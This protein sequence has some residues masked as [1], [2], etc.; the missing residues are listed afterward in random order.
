MVKTI[1]CPI[2]PIGYLVPVVQWDYWA[3]G[4]VWTIAENLAPQGFDPRIVQPVATG[5]QDYTAAIY[6][7]NKVRH[8]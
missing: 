2:Y 7:R 6:V 3:L 4:P 8:L 5:I 1:P